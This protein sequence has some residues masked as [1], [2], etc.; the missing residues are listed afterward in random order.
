[1]KTKNSNNLNY[2]R[3]LSHNTRYTYFLCPQ[4]AIIS[5]RSFS[6]LSKN[7]REV[8]KKKFFR[9]VGVFEIVK[10]S[11][12]FLQSGREVRVGVLVKCQ[13]VKLFLA[14]FQRKSRIN[15]IKSK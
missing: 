10:E 4:L 12:R 1:M 6:L 2:F 5:L 11:S 13:K 15:K 3:T 7:S 8:K 14:K 9:S